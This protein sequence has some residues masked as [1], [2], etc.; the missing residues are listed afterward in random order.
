MDHTYFDP[1]KHF[2]EQNERLL[3][4]SDRRTLTLVPSGQL[5]RPTMIAAQAE[6]IY[7]LLLLTASLGLL[8][9][10]AIT[11]RSLQ[12][13]VDATTIPL[14][15]PSNTPNGQSLNATIVSSC[16]ASIPE[17]RALGCFFDAMT[18]QWYPPACADPDLSAEVIKSRD[19]RFYTIERGWEEDLVPIEDVVAGNHEYLYVPM[20]SSLSSLPFW[21]LLCHQMGRVVV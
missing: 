21:R 20:V 10:C 19:W 7:R 1:E 6:R 17:A 9:Y 16:G 18:F 14:L 5:K 2:E 13:S 11:L 4:S 8:L 12:Q 3:P 15:L